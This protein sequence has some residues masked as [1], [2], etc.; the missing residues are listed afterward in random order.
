MT[1]YQRFGLGAGLL[2][3]ALMVGGLQ[4]IGL[5][6][7]A[8]AFL[9]IVLGDTP[10]DMEAKWYGLHEDR[11]TYPFVTIEQARDAGYET[12]LQLF[13]TSGAI[14]KVGV[15]LHPARR[16]DLEPDLGITTNLS[17]YVREGGSDGVF[18]GAYNTAGEAVFLLPP[19]EVDFAEVVEIAR[20]GDA[21][22]VVSYWT[23]TPEVDEAGL[24]YWPGY[25]FDPES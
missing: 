5:A 10:G 11:L 19:D 18:F 14:D 25:E 23:E 21:V 9:F 22:L 3:L 13:G 15:I 4:P 16:P 12:V 20:R 17:Y 7:V 6:V 2:G 8:I 1:F 24:A